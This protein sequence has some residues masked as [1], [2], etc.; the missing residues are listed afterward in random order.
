VGKTTK[1]FPS[2]GVGN[3]NIKNQNAKCKNDEIASSVRGGLAMTFYFG[4]LPAQE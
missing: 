2:T 4:F 3:N 1:K